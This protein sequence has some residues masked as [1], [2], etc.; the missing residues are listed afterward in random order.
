MDTNYKFE[1][2]HFL[3]NNL[4]SYI[5]YTNK[6]NQILNNKHKDAFKN[7]INKNCNENKNIDDIKD[8]KTS[9]K[10]ENYIKIVNNFK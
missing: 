9:N 8:I 1:W 5:N 6:E 10:P 7:N 2:N 4:K 3:I